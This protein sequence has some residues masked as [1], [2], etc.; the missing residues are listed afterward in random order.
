MRKIIFVVPVLAACTISTSCKKELAEEIKIPPVI[1]NEVNLNGWEKHFP[2]GS[3]GS[4][5]F[6]N[7]PAI[8]P[9]G[10]GSVQFYCPD[11]KNFRL[12]T[13]KYVGTHLSTITEFSYSTYIQKR[14]STVD[15]VFITLQIDINDDGIEDFALV[16]NPVYQTGRFT[17]GLRPDQGATK[18]NIWQ[19]W[20]LLKGGWWRGG[21][22]PVLDPDNGGALFTLVGWIN[23]F[24]KATIMNKV[25]G[26]FGSIRL[27]G[28]SPV[29]AGPFIGYVDD[30]KIGINGVTTTFDFEY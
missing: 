29:F 8:Q 19:T 7:G 3:L 25:G 10:T 20:D 1:V 18:M 6:V 9:L 28:G 22:L 21:A 30:F 2:A 16:F 11:K 26:V 24:P 5:N 23:Q 17:Q 15:N 27:Q 13:D 12:K 14:D 4:I